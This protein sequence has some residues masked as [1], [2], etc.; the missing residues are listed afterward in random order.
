M[1]FVCISFIPWRAGRGTTQQRE[2]L[3]TKLGGKKIV[4]ASTLLPLCVT[5]LYIYDAK[6]AEC[7]ADWSESCTHQMSD[8]PRPYR[9]LFVG[10][11]SFVSRIFIAPSVLFFSTYTHGGVLFPTPYCAILLKNNIIPACN[12]R[13]ISFCHTHCRYARTVISNLLACRH[14]VNKNLPTGFKNHTNARFLLCV[15]CVCVL[16]KPGFFHSHQNFHV[17]IVNICVNII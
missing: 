8:S 12:L 7:K 15:W 1:W 6:R 16:T 13:H 14:R 10:G 9:P 17:R 4:M 11:V 3:F 5:A 2:F